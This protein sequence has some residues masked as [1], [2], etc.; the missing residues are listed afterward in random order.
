MTTLVFSTRTHP[1]SSSHLPCTPWARR[2]PHP[3]L[4]T[5]P[6]SSSLSHCSW[7]LHPDLEAGSH[8]ILNRGPFAFHRSP[9]PPPPPSFQLR[10]PSRRIPSLYR[11]FSVIHIFC[12][13]RAERYKTRDLDPTHPRA[14]LTRPL[15]CPCAIRQIDIRLS[16]WSVVRREGNS[17]QSPR[18]DASRHRACSSRSRCWEM[19]ESAKLH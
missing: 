19:E 4:A 8:I 12:S 5:Y 16:S 17:R 6:H 15:L 14:T 3:P 13:G 11:L 2:P 10:A 9:V 18:A 1:A 7:T